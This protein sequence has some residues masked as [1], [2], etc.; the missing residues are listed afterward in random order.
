MT[1][2]APANAARLLGRARQQHDLGVLRREA[3]RGPRRRACCRCRGGRGS[4][5][6]AVAAPRWAAR[7]RARAPPATPGVGLEVGQGD[8]LLD[9]RRRVDSGGG[10]G[11]SA[12]S[13]SKG[14]TS[15][16][17][18]LSASRKLMRCMPVAPS[19]VVE[20]RAVEPQQPRRH[21]EVVGA[22]ADGLPEAACRARS[23]RARQS[24]ARGPGPCPRSE[25]P[26]W[27][28]M[29]VCGMPKRSSSPS[30]WA[31][32]RAVTVRV[33]AG[34]VEAPQDGPE[35]EHVRR[36]GE[37]DPDLRATAGAAIGRPRGRRR[38]PA[39]LPDV[40][41]ERRCRTAFRRSTTRPRMGHHRAPGPRRGVCGGDD[42]AVGR[43]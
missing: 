27:R 16:T 33:H 18:T 8:L 23:A 12:A 28:P 26:P 25:A 11:P 35:E 19:I 31:K 36:V 22:V 40:L 41:P 38:W 9:A 15:G 10:R 29:T 14:M 37:V 43:R 7:G 21:G 3:A 20:D 6:P 4:W 1:P 24:A 2:G 17:M 34:L 5:W 32:S 42:D 13:V 30:V 39:R